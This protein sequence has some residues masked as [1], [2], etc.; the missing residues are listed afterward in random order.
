VAGSEGDRRH[1]LAHRLF[2]RRF[3]SGLY[4]APPFTLAPEMRMT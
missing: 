3:E 4:R 2:D 1:R